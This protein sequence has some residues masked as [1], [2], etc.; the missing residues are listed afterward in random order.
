MTRDELASRSDHVRHLIQVIDARDPE[1]DQIDYAACK[2]CGIGI[3]PHTGRGRPR[4]FCSV[5]C[6]KSF[7]N[8]QHPECGRAAT[9]RYRAKRGRSR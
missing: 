6:R 5:R 3:E 7:W 1:P 4:K 8:K 2:N 9:R